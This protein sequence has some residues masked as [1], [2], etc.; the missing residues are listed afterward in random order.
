MSQWPT[1]SGRGGS[2]GRLL[3]RLAELRVLLRALSSEKKDPL[4]EEREGIDTFKIV[5]Q[6]DKTVYTQVYI[7]TRINY[8]CILNIYLYNVMLCVNKPGNNI[9]SKITSTTQDIYCCRCAAC[10]V[11]HSQAGL[12][13]SQNHRCRTEA[14][15]GNTLL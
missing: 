13:D 15:P 4:E 10:E 7:R 11:M 9:H 8:T 14:F 5:V 12:I 2:G 1:D 3:S 6:R